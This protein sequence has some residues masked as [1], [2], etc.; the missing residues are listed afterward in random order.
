MVGANLQIDARNVEKIPRDGMM[1]L[2]KSIA[3]AAG[4]EENNGGQPFYVMDLGA[5]EG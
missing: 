5:L 2:I 1:E 4:N 3:A